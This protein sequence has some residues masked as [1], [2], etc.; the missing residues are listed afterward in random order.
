MG[1]QGGPWLVGREV[2]GAHRLTPRHRTLT[3]AYAPPI[4]RHARKASV[5]THTRTHAHTPH[6]YTHLDLV[7]PDGVVHVP[8]VVYKRWLGG[9]GGSHGVAQ[10][11]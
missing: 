9:V 1:M 5:D 6:T 8:D 4:R 2:V 3:C 10:M 11:A 7:G